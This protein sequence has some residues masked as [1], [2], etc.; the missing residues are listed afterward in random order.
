VEQEAMSMALLGYRR[1]VREDG[2]IGSELVVALLAALIPPVPVLEP[3]V[4]L[5]RE[6]SRR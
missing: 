3:M 5:R 2:R 6:A 4:A 1:Q